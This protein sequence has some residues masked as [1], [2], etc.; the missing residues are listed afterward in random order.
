MSSP[1]S[2]LVPSSRHDS[3]SFQWQ[4]SSA[5]GCHHASHF[6]VDQWSLLKSA[7]FL[8][9]KGPTIDPGNT[10]TDR[11]FSQ[12]IVFG[13]SL[14]DIGNLSSVAA[15]FDII[16]PPL[17][18]AQTG[19]I[20]KAGRMTNGDLTQPEV[21]GNLWVEYFAPRVGL[22]DQVKNLAVI[23]S[24]SG[25]ANV[26]PATA[27]D[28]GITLPEELQLP[29]VL[30][31]IAGYVADLNTA[32]QPADPDALY[33]VWGGATDF[34][35]LFPTPSLSSV[36]NA[37]VAGVANVAKAVTTLVGTGAETIVVPNLPNLGLTP[38]A[39]GY[40]AAGANVVS[41][42]TLFSIGFDLLLQPTLTVLERKLK[43]VNPEVDIIQID[44]F[45]LSEA[46]ADGKFGFEHTIDPLFSH[47]S[48]PNLN[49][50]GFAFSDPFHPTTR[51]H[52]VFAD[53]FQAAL[54]RPVASRVLQSSIEAINDLIPSREG[55]SFI[56]SLFGM[57]PEHHH[58]K[59]SVYPNRMAA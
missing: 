19:S 21:P 14:S 57:A 11:S 34:L 28:L 6:P 10:L 20:G 12:L 33:V 5:F 9:G 2:T 17:P 18:F 49:P 38:F 16:F 4:Q 35:T 50:N 45:S 58:F 27:A 23:G 7:S 48:D 42:A 31:Q 53:L 47:L 43:Q 52:Q 29:G 8:L 54:S 24:T 37:I 41:E 15:N 44:T 30:D 40:N 25:H 46:I 22:Q 56:S 59:H 26:V 36:V 13:D 3:F 32:N 51:V 55:A 1:L 39:A